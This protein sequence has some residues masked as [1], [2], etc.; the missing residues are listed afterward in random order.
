LTTSEADVGV[1]EID[2]G[3]AASFSI[4][5][6][7]FA[8]DTAMT[9]VIIDSAGASTAFTMTPNGDKSVWTGS[10][11]VLTTPGEYTAKFTTTGTGLGVKFHTVIVA[12]VPPFNADIRRVRLLIADTDPAN[13]LFRADQ[14]TDFLDMEGGSVKLAA[15]QALDSIAVSEVLISKVIKTQD[16]STDGAKVAAELRARAK[17]LRRQ[18]TDSEGDDDGGFV[19]V[20]FF[21]PFTRTD[22][23]Y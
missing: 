7:P 21:D 3:D 22:Y 5:V 2:A 14:V 6:T 15:A 20:D 23:E 16:L 11:Q 19:I 8:I 4:A 1:L 18:V 17:E 13:R 12:T 10:S 9:A